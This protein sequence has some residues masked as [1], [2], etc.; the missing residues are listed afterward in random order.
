MISNEFLVSCNNKRIAFFPKQVLHEK[1]S[2]VFEI[3]FLRKLVVV[4]LLNAATDFMP[5]QTGMV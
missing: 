2:L 4:L 5:Q 1:H 3:F